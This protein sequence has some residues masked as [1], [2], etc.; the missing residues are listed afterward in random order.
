MYVAAMYEGE[1][2]YR[3]EWECTKCGK[4]YQENRI[5]VPEASEQDKKLSEILNGK[6]RRSNRS[7]NRSN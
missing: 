6:K 2:K 3:L 4:V 7:T 5:E 1:T